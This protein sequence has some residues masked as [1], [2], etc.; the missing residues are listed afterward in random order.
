MSGAVAD[1]PLRSYRVTALGNHI[2]G[3]LGVTECGHLHKETQEARQCAERP[4]L[5]AARMVVT[6]LYQNGGCQHDFEGHDLMGIEAY[7]IRR[8][9]RDTA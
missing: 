3:Y 4:L 2:N 6:H 7:L 1:Q 9:Q 8:W 5:R